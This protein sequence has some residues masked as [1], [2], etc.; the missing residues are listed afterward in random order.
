ML[1][2]DRPHPTFNNP[3]TNTLR[4]PGAGR[5]VDPEAVGLNVGGGRMGENDSATQEGPLAQGVNVRARTDVDAGADTRAARA[6]GQPVTLDDAAE[7]AGSG[8]E[9]G[10]AEV[11]DE[12][13]IRPPPE[14]DEDAAETQQSPEAMERLHLVQL[15]QLSRNELLLE[16]NASTIAASNFEA[17]IEQRL[18]GI[19]EPDM[20]ELDNHRR[21]KNLAQKF[22]RGQLVRFDS[23]EEKAAVL[24]IAKNV[25]RRH[26]RSPNK[27]KTSNEDESP[28]AGAAQPLPKV[29]NFSP[30]PETVQTAMVEKIVNGK[31]DTAGSFSG[32]KYKQPVLNTVARAMTMNSSY[33]AGDG[34]RLLKKVR[35]LLPATTPPGQ[36]R[37]AQGQGQGQ[38]AKGGR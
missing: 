26:L 13:V 14:E 7:R 32:E 30:L 6:T 38:G 19:A 2:R 28:E 5:T 23:K 33:L 11:R 37:Q 35:G 27:T 34:E 9:P 24:E 31:Y 8:M 10:R 3:D 1:Q 22:R 20:S 18:R 16:Q 25:A 12:R 15:E 36:Q 21:R 29:Y 17:V 4:P